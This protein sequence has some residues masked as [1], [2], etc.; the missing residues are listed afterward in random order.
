MYT[1][2]GHSEILTSDTSD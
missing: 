1:Q 2:Q